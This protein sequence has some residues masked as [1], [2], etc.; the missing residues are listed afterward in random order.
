MLTEDENRKSRSWL[1]QIDRAGAFGLRRHRY[2]RPLEVTLDKIPS[3]KGP[4]WNELS[5][6]HLLL[7]CYWWHWSTINSSIFRASKL[8]Y[9]PYNETPTLNTCDPRPTTLESYGKED[10]HQSSRR[11]TPGI[12]DDA[13]THPS[14]QRYRTQ[15]RWKWRGLRLWTLRITRV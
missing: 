13:T 4:A 12:R 5:L 6:F 3:F 10:W 7:I 1:T 11:A 15:P 14:Y 2:T 8:L 9:T